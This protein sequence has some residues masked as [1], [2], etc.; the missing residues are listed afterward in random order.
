MFRN[1]VPKEED[2]GHVHAPGRQSGAQGG[3]D[4]GPG[5]DPVG[6]SSAQPRC[7]DTVDTAANVNFFF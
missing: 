2:P 6:A 5:A 4:Q 3:L 1:L 7:G